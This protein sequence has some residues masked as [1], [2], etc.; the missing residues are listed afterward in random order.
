ML[1]PCVSSICY[2]AT[3]EAISGVL[4]GLRLSTAPFYHLNDFLVFVSILPE[5]RK[6]ESL[7]SS[8]TR[9]PT[10]NTIWFDA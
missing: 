10:S 3:G 7:W 6:S 5:H 1:G 4:L 9:S 8:T 2:A